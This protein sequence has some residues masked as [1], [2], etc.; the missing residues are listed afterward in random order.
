MVGLSNVRSQETAAK[1]EPPFLVPLAVLLLLLTLYVW[2]RVV[3]AIALPEIR[4]ALGLSPHQVG[5]LASAFAGGIALMAVPSGIFVRRLGL[6]PVL[7]M[8]A[9]LF[10]LATAYPPVAPS[11]R[12]LLISRIVIG[13]GEGMFNVSL[14]RYLGTISNRYR[15]SLVGLAA[16][17]FGVGAFIGP[18]A[19]QALNT[20]ARSWRTGFFALAI[21]GVLLS[22][23]LLSFRELSPAAWNAGTASSEDRIRWTRLIEYWPL[24]ILVAVVGLSVYSV[25]G[26][27]PTWTRENFSYSK[28]AAALVLGAVG[29]GGI[30]GGAPAG[31]IADRLQ[32]ERYA[33]CTAVINGLSVIG[34]MAFNFG[35]LAAYI[36]AVIF[37]AASNSLYVTTIIIGQER[38][39]ADA[40]ALVGFIATIFYGSAFFSGIVITWA[41]A[42]SV[43]TPALSPCISSFTFA[44]P[45]LLHCSSKRAPNR[46]MAKV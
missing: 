23:V 43:T 11:Y 20:A 26:L 15:A 1:D 44:V 16:T 9:L 33:I 17:V 28:S 41:A 8:G 27:L 4:T 42:A 37:G 10:S 25:T 45:S 31:L 13:I 46:N 38:A 19:I 35:L 2:D 12:S 14:L 5:V 32:R 21:A 24:L 30:L 7:L 3:F 18:N 39:G 29:L 34:L 40:P 6:R 22:C 36:L